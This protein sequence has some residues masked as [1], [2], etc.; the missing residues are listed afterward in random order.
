MKRIAMINGTGL[1][2]NTAVWDGAT[3]WLPHTP[4]QI[5]EGWALVDVTMRPEV[6]SGWSYGAEVFT[7]PP[8]QQTP[9]DI[10]VE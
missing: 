4:E 3:V 5:A 8:V 6:G 7:P 1:V 2:Y 10:V 9:P